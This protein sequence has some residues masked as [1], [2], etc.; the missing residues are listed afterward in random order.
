MVGIANC[1]VRCPIWSPSPA[2][3]QPRG[4]RCLRRAT[5]SHTG[6]SRRLRQPSCGSHSL[7]KA[8]R[9]A[10]HHILSWNRSNLVPSF[11]YGSE[12]ATRKASQI[13]ATL[14]PWPRR[15][16]RASPANKS[17]VLPAQVIIFHRT[18]QER[19]EFIVQIG[20]FPVSNQS[21]DFS[22]SWLIAKRTAAPGSFAPR[23]SAER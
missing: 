8:R 12:P 13:R 10:N 20:S 6:D 5:L 15:D 19:S 21:T 11:L 17:S 14:C 7:L 16:Y 1:L 18:S 23:S 22:N 4:V 9:L 3:G 2:F